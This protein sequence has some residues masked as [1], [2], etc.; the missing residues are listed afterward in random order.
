MPAVEKKKIALGPEH[1]EKLRDA[2]R[3]VLRQLGA[4]QVRH[5]WGVAGS[6]ELSAL[7]VDLGDQRVLFEAETYMGL[8]ITGPADLVDRIAERINESRRR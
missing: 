5:D 2:V 4:S 3:D 8:S 6:Q 7:E 1:D